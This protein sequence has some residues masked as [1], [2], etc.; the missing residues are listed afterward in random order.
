MD[1]MREIFRIYKVRKFQFSLIRFLLKGSY[2]DKIYIMEPSVLILSKIKK[3]FPIY[4]IPTA[5]LGV[6][7]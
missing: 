1:Q 2:F 7:S 5:H 4:A 6:L 3:L